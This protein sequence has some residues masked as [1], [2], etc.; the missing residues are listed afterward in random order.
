MSVR[1]LAECDAYLSPAHVRPSPDRVRRREQPRLFKAHSDG[2]HSFSDFEETCVATL[3]EPHVSLDRK[4]MRSGKLRLLAV[5]F[6]DLHKSGLR[7][8]E[9]GGSLAQVVQRT[10]D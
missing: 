9:G 10:G 5:Q 3:K 4:Q 6:A 8:L 2:A 7:F 1:V